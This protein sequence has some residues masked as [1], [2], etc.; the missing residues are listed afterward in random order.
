MNINLLTALTVLTISLVTVFLSAL[1]TYLISRTK[2][3]LN[4]SN[5]FKVNSQILVI[6]VETFLIVSLFF[7]IEYTL[8]SDITSLEKKYEIILLGIG[9]LL[10]LLLMIMTLVNLTILLPPD[11]K[12]R[13]KGLAKKILEKLP[14]AVAKVLEKILNKVYVTLKNLAIENC[15]KLIHLLGGDENSNEDNT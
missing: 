4:F 2:R 7:R 13:L 3:V 5:A 10:N 6:M 8:E 1:S 12:Q 15:K 9:I 11:L 14:A